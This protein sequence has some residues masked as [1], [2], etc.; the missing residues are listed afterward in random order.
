MRP[1]RFG[2]V[3]APGTDPDEWAARCRRAEQ[4]GYDV[5]LLPDHLGMGAPLPALLAAAAH[6]RRP[7]LGTFVLNAGFWRPA[8]LRREV[9]ALA[10][11]TG[12]RLELG[13]GAGYDREEFAAAGIG[14]LTARDRVEHLA[15]TLD[16]LRAEPAAH[17][18]LIGGTGDAVLRLAARHADIVGFT[19]G[20]RAAVGRPPVLHDYGRLAERIA[21]VRDAA[22]DRAA[23][24][25]LNLFVHAVVVTADPPAAARQLAVQAGGVSTAELLALPTVLIG[26]AAEIADRLIAHRAALGITYFTVREAAMDQ[27]AAVIAELAGRETLTGPRPG[28]H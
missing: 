24:L 18:L 17:P 26:S 10:G 7:R 5:L 3:L 23:D 6:T 22:G 27:F 14:L 2:V 21:F 11:L 9:A 19:P 25:E 12:G 16:A 15:E 28:G 20:R 4:C 8:L 1:F 13:L